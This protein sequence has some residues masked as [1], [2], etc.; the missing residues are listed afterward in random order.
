MK[1]KV[2]T[3]PKTEGIKCAL[4]KINFTD[5]FSTTN[6]LDDLNTVS[7]LV[8][9]TMPKWVE[10]LMK[11]RNTIVKIF[12]LKA[13]KPEDFHPDFKIGGYVG[14]FQIFSIQ[15]NEI[16]LGADDKHLNFRVSIYNSN[17]NQFNIKVTTLVQYNNR[18]GRIYMAIVKP[19]H[20]LVVKRMV[21]QAY[22]SG[23]RIE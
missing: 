14:F 1:V 16:M 8:F 7:K 11:L 13:E 10:V 12:G 23:F 21:K 6:H 2:E 15:K 20:H 4:P 5:T 9:G 3:M 18:F 22:K 19:F 17:D